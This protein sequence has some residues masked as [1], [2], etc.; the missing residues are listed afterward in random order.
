MSPLSG[1]RTGKPSPPRNH[2]AFSDSLTTLP[3]VVLNELS[4]VHA[5]QAVWRPQNG[6]CHSY[7]GPGTGPRSVEK[8]AH[9]EASLG[10][11][12]CI[13]P[14]QLAEPT[15]QKADLGASI[16]GIPVGAALRARSPEAEAREC[17]WIGLLLRL[18][19]LSTHRH[20]L[21]ASSQARPLTPGTGISGV[22]LRTSSCAP[23]PR[24][25]VRLDLTASLLLT[26]HLLRSRGLGFQSG[27]CEA[28]NS[29]DDNL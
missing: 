24:P 21:S 11:N 22:P 18:L 25:P 8:R 9:L 26:H 17:L 12:S 2:P 6:L 27:N 23:L 20:I 5:V 28:Y 1:D 13:T 10:F 15:Q 19:S 3:P 4:R 16:M 7:C 14:Y 29:A